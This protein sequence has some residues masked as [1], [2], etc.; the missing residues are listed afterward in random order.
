MGEVFVLVYVYL[1]NLIHYFMELFVF[2]V[3]VVD[4]FYV[5]DWSLLS[6]KKCIYC[7]EGGAMHTFR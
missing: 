2:S 4:L 7:K 1:R 5:E 6:K 3:C